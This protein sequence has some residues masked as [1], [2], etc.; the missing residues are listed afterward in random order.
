MNADPVVLVSKAVVEAASR[1]QILRARK[2]K[3]NRLVY[4]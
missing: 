1:A 3:E 2:A 4:S